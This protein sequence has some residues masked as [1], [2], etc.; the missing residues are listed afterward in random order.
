M[1][2]LVRNIAPVTVMGGTGDDTLI[3]NGNPT[4]FDNLRHTPT[5]L[6][7]GTVI[8]DNQPFPVITFTGIEHLKL[9]LQSGEGDGARVD[10]T[11]GDDRFR[12]FHG[13]TADAGMIIGTLD[14]NN[15]TGGGPFALTETT[16]SGDDPVPN[17]VDINFFVP[18]GSDTIEFNG[19]SGDDVISV[20]IGEGGG[21]QLSNSL[22][23]VVVS[24]VE[25]FNMASADVQ[26][27]GGND[28]FSVAPSQ[29]VAINVFGGL[30][31]PP[32]V[33]GDELKVNVAGTLGGNLTVS[34]NAS[35]KFGSFTF[36]NRMKVAFQE[37]ETIA[38]GTCPGLTCALVVGAAARKQQGA[39][40]FDLPLTLSIP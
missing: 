37:I 27:A 22:A 35:G 31:A 18:G 32:A 8:N 38:T 5:G 13:A 7:A 3:A 21:A 25:A 14:Q 6:G 34:T 2:N 39:G 20:G 9:V 30:P 15:A 24:R 4:V 28:V 17:D 29:F 36:T 23:G 26:G 33:P 16:Y 10:G 12:F 11:I 19:T 1:I 40:A